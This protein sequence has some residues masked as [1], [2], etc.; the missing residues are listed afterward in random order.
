MISHLA[1]HGCGLFRCP[2]RAMY[3]KAQS[4]HISS[5]F[6]LRKRTLPR[7]PERRLRL[8]QALGRVGVGAETQARTA[9]SMTS[10]ARSRID[11]GTKLVR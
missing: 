7:R 5:A 11:E 9:Y 3:R 8:V 2:D 4:E 10:S 6:S 1:L